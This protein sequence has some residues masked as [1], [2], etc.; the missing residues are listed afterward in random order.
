MVSKKVE[1]IPEVDNSKILVENIARYEFGADW[2][3]VISNV[4]TSGVQVEDNR[5]VTVRVSTYESLMT[6]SEVA[7]VAFRFDVDLDALDNCENLV[8]GR[9]NSDWTIIRTWWFEINDSD[10]NEGNSYPGSTPKGVK[11]RFFYSDTRKAHSVH[12]R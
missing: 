2:G 7:R 9:P 4:D 12:Y 5:V 8:A 10:R 6:L 1:T 3:S 11:L